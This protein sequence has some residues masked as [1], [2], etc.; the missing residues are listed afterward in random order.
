MSGCIDQ[1]NNK[2]C[3]TL[4]HKPLEKV[5]EEEEKQLICNK[6]G[7]CFDFVPVGQP[8]EEE[9]KKKIICTTLVGGYCK[10]NFGDDDDKDYDKFARLEGTIAGL[11][12]QEAGV[13]SMAQSGQG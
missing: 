10:K 12:S 9:P 4:E 8:I 7:A 13:A 3:C 6:P 2:A 11:K 1:C 5:A